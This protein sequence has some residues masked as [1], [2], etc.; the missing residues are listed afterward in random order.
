MASTLSS[1]AVHSRRLDR[2]RAQGWPI[3]RSHRAQDWPTGPEGPR[4]PLRRLP[5]CRGSRGFAVLHPQ[6]RPSE[7]AMD[8]LKKLFNYLVYDYKLLQRATW[9]VIGLLT[10]VGLADG[11]VNFGQT[12]RR[13]P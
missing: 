2:Q 4:R 3:Y 1:T 13:A 11:I 9:A 10:S 5:N 12:A 6:E 8:L 7:R